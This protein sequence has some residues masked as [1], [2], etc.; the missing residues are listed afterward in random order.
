MVEADAAAQR[1][2]EQVVDGV[3]EA[4]AGC[5]VQLEQRQRPKPRAAWGACKQAAAVTANGRCVVYAPCHMARGRRRLRRRR[6][7]EGVAWLTGEAQAA[8]GTQRCCMAHGGRRRRRAHSTQGCRMTHE[9]AQGAWHAEVS[10]GARQ[11][12]AKAA[13]GTLRCRMTDRGGAGH[14]AHRGVARRTAASTAKRRSR[15][16]RGVRQC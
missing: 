12:E 6:A 9:G 16:A 13:H 5:S 2:G 8:H 7:R 4:T 15:P 3:D 1:E 10:H 14:M 11:A